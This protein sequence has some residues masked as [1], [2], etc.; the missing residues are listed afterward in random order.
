ML[1]VKTTAVA[2]AALLFSPSAWAQSV[3]A[4]Y[5]NK[6]VRFIC[7]FPPGGANDLLARLFAQ[8]MTDA[9]GQQVIVDNRGGAG[10]QTRAVNRVPA[11]GM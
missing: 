5:P 3:A 2:V 10:G 6:V 7:P 9:Y 8:K 11:C 4:N 1:S